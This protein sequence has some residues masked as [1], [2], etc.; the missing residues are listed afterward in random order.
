MATN[1]AGSCF[2]SPIPAPSRLWK[3]SAAKAELLIA[4]AAATGFELQEAVERE[5]LV[6][7]GT[8]RFRRGRF[9]L[10]LI[11]AP[12]PFEEVVFERAQHHELFGVRLPWY[13]DCVRD[14]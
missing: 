8:L 4:R 1:R 11:T 14:G 7:T 5:R 12:L 9:Q 13:A 3:K 2:R 6:T 10:D